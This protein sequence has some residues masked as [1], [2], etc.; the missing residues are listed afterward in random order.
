MPSSRM[1]MRTSV[2]SALYETDKL[3]REGIPQAGFEATKTFLANYSNLWAQDASRRLGFA[4]D[5][6]VTGKDVVK[7]LQAR[8]PK[9]KKSEVDAAVRKHLGVNGLTISIVADKAQSIADTL[10]SGGPTG[11]S[12]D[13]AG[14]PPDVVAEDDLIKRFPIPLEKENV[15]VYPVDK[16]FEK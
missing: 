11:I 3:V 13:T 6:V 1:A 7:E 14:T 2:S 5:A 15:R 12:Y 4:I 16:M 9:M 8:L 10:M